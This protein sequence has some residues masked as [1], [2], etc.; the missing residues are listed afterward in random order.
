MRWNLSSKS[1]TGKTTKGPVLNFNVTN[2][3]GLEV[4]T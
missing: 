3:Q 1:A 2:C 4:M